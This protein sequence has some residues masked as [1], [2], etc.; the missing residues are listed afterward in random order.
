MPGVLT[1][2]PLRSKLPA[3]SVPPAPPAPTDRT[4]SSD[5]DAFARTYEQMRLLARQHLQGEK[6]G[7]TLQAT[8]LAHEAWLRL[9]ERS[10]LQGA[11]DRTFQQ[12]ASQAMRRILIDHARS[13]GR[14]K[15]GGPWQRLPIDALEL[16]ASGSFD[17][18]L[19]V[20]EAIEKL[21]A[22]EPRLAELVR[23]R[24][25]SGLGVDETARVLGCAERTVVREWSYAK[26]WLLRYLQSGRE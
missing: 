21:A 23:L 24:F 1:L 7:H 2:P 5:D 6:K 13:R 12:A 15:R 20:D 10:D 16:T 8:A 26:A 3:M 11:D 19:A 22:Q 25:F 14:L 4:P 18:L 9:L 17:D